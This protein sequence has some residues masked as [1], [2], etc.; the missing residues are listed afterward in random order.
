MKVTR[1]SYPGWNN[2]PVYHAPY[3]TYQK[4]DAWMRSNGVDSFLL[5]SGSMGYVFQVK[6]NHEWFVLRWL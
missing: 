6:S 3:E 4:V 1:T 2:Y 5:Q